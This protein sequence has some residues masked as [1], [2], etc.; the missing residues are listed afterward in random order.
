M[1]EEERLA[2]DDLWSDSNAT[3]GGCSPGRS[4]PWEPG[5]LRETVVE[6]HAR[7]SEVEEL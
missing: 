6:V 4:T 7:D 2:F 1:E 5:S 3:A